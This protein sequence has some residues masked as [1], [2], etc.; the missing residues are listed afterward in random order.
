[1]GGQS[2]Q[3]I[4]TKDLSAQLKLTQ[5]H[6]RRILRSLPLYDDGVYT[7]YA[8]LKDDPELPKVSALIAARSKR[9]NRRGVVTSKGQLVIPAEIRRRYHI[10]KGTHVNIE[11]LDNGILLR[12]INDESIERVRGILAGKGLPDRIEKEPDREIR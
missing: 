6:I 9:R 12:P 2:K 3:V 10:E 1:M 4:R 8:W 11:E 5:K 7:K